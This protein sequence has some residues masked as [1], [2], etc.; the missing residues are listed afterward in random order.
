MSGGVDSAVALLRAGPNAIGVTLRLWLDPGGPDAE[1]ACCS[2]EAVIAARRDLSRAR[3]AARDAR[4]ARG[5]PPRRRRAVRRAATRAARR[6]TRAS[7]ATA[8]SASTSCSRSRDRAGA[9]RLATGH[10]ARIVE[11]DGRRAARPR[12][13]PGTR[14]SRY[15][16][17]HARPRDARAGSGSRSASQTKAETRAR[18]GAPPGSTSPSARE[19]QE[20]CFLAGDD[21]RSFLER[22]GLDRVG[23][24]RS[25]T[26]HGASS[27][28]TTA[29]GASRPASGAGSASP[30]PSRS[31]RCAPSRA[32]TRVVVGPRGSL[33]RTDVD[34]RGPPPR[35]GRPRR[36][37]A[38]L[39]LARGPRARPSPRPRRLRARARRSRPTASRRASPPSSTTDDAVV[40]CGVV[41]VRAA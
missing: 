40:G 12:R 35:P 33:A 6:R 2:P 32:R 15:M 22:H 34:V 30:P 16:L 24:A 23:R 3:A 27:A 26:R 7:A 36:G 4:P 11:R 39:P 17:A 41:V 31:T 21:Y 18:G 10:Y 14:T 1:R 19:S 13:R 20:A 5:V 25:S 38:P 37:E 28:A 8:A 9:G 29:S